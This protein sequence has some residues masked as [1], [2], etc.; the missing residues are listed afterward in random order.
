MA[1]I[2]RYNRVESA[3]WTDPAFAAWSDKTRLLALYIL[4]CPH[5]RAEGLFRLPK[6]Y[7]SADL[8]WTLNQLEAPF[9]E[10]LRAGFIEYDE[11][12]S[13]CLIPR[14]LQWEAPNT[15][16]VKGCVAAFRELPDSP[17]K[18]RFYKLCEHHSPSLAEG[19]REAFGKAS[20][21]LSERCSGEVPPL[22]LALTPSPTHPQARAG[23]EGGEVE[24]DIKDL[25]RPGSQ[26]T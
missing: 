1:A 11:A 26:V 7:I 6:Q 13:T 23:E 15:N 24:F 8:G 25:P 3:L 9:G 10:L 2:R 4:T 19:L 20:E 18:G 22:A 12:T 16:Q 17:L 21:T 5:R 14:A